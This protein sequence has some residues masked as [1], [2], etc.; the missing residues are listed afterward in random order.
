MIIALKFRISYSRN[1]QNFSV[2]GQ[3]VSMLGFV[4]HFITVQLLN[5][6]CKQAVSTPESVILASALKG[7]SHYSLFI[8]SWPILAH[9]P[10][11][12]TSEAV[13]NFRHDPCTPSTGPGEPGAQ[14][15]SH[16]SSFLQGNSMMLLSHCIGHGPE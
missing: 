7:S 11:Y 6:A 3:T 2:K 10:F 16:L 4:S 13:E 5:S 12:S 14:P 1:W 8:L 15:Q 9:W